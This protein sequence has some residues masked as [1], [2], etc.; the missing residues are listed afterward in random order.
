MTATLSAA[1]VLVISSS[2]TASWVAEV[3]VW[4]PDDQTLAVQLEDIAQEVL[5]GGTT[6]DLMEAE[7]A[8]SDSSAA[9]ELISQ[10]DLLTVAVI[11]SG[12]AE[13]ER[14]AA[15][16]AA[17]AVDLYHERTNGASRARVL[18]LARGGAQRTS[19]QV[20]RD[21]SLAAVTG[22][23][24][25]IAVAAS[26]SRRA[27][28]SAP[29]PLALFGRRGWRPLAIIPERMRE[30]NGVPPSA[31]QLAA[32]LMCDNIVDGSVT[33]FLALHAEADAGIPARQAARA[34]AGRGLR[35][36]WLDA[37]VEHLQPLALPLA[38]GAAPAALPL[39]DLD[40]M[41]LPAWLHGAPPPPWS[42]RLRSLLAANRPR[43]DRI[44]IVAGAAAVGGRALQAAAAAD[45]VV[46]ASRDGY[47]P[48]PSE[49]AALQAL[50]APIL[51]VALT[52]AS[53]HRA[54][55]FAEIV[56]SLGGEG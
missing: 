36:L 7:D 55:A 37:Q 14:L 56:D 3:R 21:T 32:A 54:A 11:A 42:E 34:L 23:L 48:G 4:S 44:V 43:F 26:L 5:A 51:G 35:T 2:A 46:L 38:G 50:S 47:G 39:P 53:E 25:G 22:L 40:S 6:L 15:G 1:V 52:H 27:P 28:A 33:V 45:Q 24:G 31:D 16:L 49:T 17:V 13:A 30:R 20:A 12:G 19:P 8:T 10:P 9:T 18:G 29:S 41:A